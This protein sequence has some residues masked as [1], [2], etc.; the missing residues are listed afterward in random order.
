MELIHTDTH[1]EEKG[2]KEIK[3]YTKYFFD[4]ET[5]Q[6]TLVVTEDCDNPYPNQESY[7]DRERG[8]RVL[9]PE[10]IPPIVRK[11]IEQLTNKK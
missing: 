10:E 1:K 5:G 3:T 4:R 2:W 9:K 11:K 6:V 8:G 7:S